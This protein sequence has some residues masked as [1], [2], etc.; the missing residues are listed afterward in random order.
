MSPYL[1]TL[2]MEGLTLMLNRRVR[3]SNN[4]TY[5]RYCSNLNIINLCF[6]DDLFLFAH[7]DVESARVIM[8]TL[9]EFKIASGITPS[10]PKSTAYFCN[11]LNY[12]K[13]GILTILPFEEG[14]LP[15]KY[16]GVPLVPSRLVYRDCNEL[17]EKVKRRVSDWKNKFLSFAGRTQLIRSVLSSMHLYWAL[18]FILPSSLMHELE[19][20]MGGV[21]ESGGVWR[22]GFLQVRPFS[23]GPFFSGLG[24]GKMVQPDSHDH[25]FFECRIT[26][27]VWEHLKS[28]TGISNLPSNHNAIVNFIKPLAKMRSMRSVVSKLVFAAS[29]YFIWQ[30]RNLRLFQKSKRSQD[31]VIEIIKSNVRLKLLPCSFKNTP[32]VKLISHIWK[33]PT[34][35]IRK[36]SQ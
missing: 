27:R 24:I 14:K 20:V 5:H 30:E 32:N 22:K 1:F 25:L 17:M 8:D 11:V 29:C 4:F 34:S 19:R 36:I 2:V 21:D 13:I 23:K 33:L 10:L 28:Y 15:V 9:E 26:S 16:L 7:G 6:A 31:Q 35:C 3:V 18:V 12:V